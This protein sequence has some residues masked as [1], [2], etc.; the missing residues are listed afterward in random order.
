MITKRFW[1]F[2]GRKIF[3][4]WEV[5]IKEMK[6]IGIMKSKYY[7]LSVLVFILFIFISLFVL[8]Q[9]KEIT[10]KIEYTEYFPPKLARDFYPNGLTREILLQRLP[11]AIQKTGAIE[12]DE[13]W[14][15]VVRI[16]GDLKITK[17]VTVTVKPGTIVF[18][19]AGSDD[20]HGGVPAPKDAFNPKDPVRDE[21]YVKSHVE[22]FDEGNLIVRGT[23][24]LP[25][26]ITSDS[27]EP[28]ADDWMGISTLRGAKLEF[29]RVI[30]EYFRILGVNSAYVSINQ[31]IV[32]N[33]LETVVIMGEGDEL[34]TLNPTITHSHLYNAGHHVIT[35]RSGSPIITHNVIRSHPD[36]E[37]PG[38]EQGAIAMDYPVANV[39]IKNNYLEGNQP[40][41]FS[42]ETSIGWRE[43]TTA[44]G[45]VLRGMTYFEFVNN[46][47]VNSENG[48]G[49]YPGPW[50]IEDNN[51]FNNTV[52][53]F[54]D[55]SKFE[56]SD[57]WQRELFE[58]GIIWQPEVENPFS[59]KNNFWGTANQTEIAEKI[60]GRSI[61]TV[62]FEPF[63]TDFIKEALPDWQEFV[64]D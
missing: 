35:I 44:E 62:E 18:V 10:P 21:N 5:F 8:L 37:L 12:Q 47:V 3:H 24:E 22:I 27:S 6:Q 38:F 31:S 19:A 9:E 58:K 16:T 49:T 55:D 56:P 54:L 7:G 45:V 53:L 26:I 59:V 1:R 32:R 25:I 17:G 50:L 60:Q 20:Q 4:Y 61:A 64:W 15:R 39:T 33:M 52:N 51:I 30:I 34:L 43:W 40:L 11:E 48:L 29:H 46:T 57:A 28:Q 63:R 14:E 41:K 2:A 36:M 42:A 13:N 23:K